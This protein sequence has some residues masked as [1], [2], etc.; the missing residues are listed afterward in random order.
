MCQIVVLCSIGDMGKIS[1]SIKSKCITKS[2]ILLNPFTSMI[3]T[4]LDIPQNKQ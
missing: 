4:Q 1:Q 2:E 3:I